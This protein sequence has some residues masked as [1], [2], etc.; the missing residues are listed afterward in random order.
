MAALPGTQHRGI[1]VHAEPALGPPPGADSTAWNAYFEDLYRDAGGECSRIPWADERPNAP[2]VAWLNRE[3]PGMM[4]PGASVVVVGCGLG[5]DVRELAERGYDPTGFDISP[6]A[7]AWAKKRFPHLAE[8]FHVAD[9]FAPPS[10][11]LRR[12]DLV[13]EVNTL[14][15]VHPD[16]RQ[17]AVS[18]I[19]S[20]ARP[21]GIILA[22]C[23]GRSEA[24]P[25]APAPPFAMSPTDLVGPFASHG[26][27]PTRGV[28][29]FVDEESPPKRCLR[30]AF[31][32]ADR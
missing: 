27:T 31:R 2:L 26:W 7:M 24:E 20:L 18:G 9:V 15:A 22:I 10:G 25:H 14:Q 21:R 17:R 19:V 5:D 13:V 8:R 32:R 6:T 12:A 3:A 1:E 4:R 28:D 16:L 29:D 30:V 23:R 11:M